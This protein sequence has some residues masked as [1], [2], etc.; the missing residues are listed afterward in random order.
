MKMNFEF[1]LED[2]QAALFRSAQRNEDFLYGEFYETDKI[3]AHHKIDEIVE[4]EGKK[5]WAIREHELLWNI[6]A[7]D[8]REEAKKNYESYLSYGQ[9]DKIEIELDQIWEVKL[10][11]VEMK[12]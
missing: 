8:T 12:D 6:I 9:E 10:V 3:G 7:A 4:S 2:I 5:F 11:L 1:E